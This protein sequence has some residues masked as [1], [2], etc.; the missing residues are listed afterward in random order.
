MQEQ[1]SRDQLVEL[2][3]RIMN[4]EGT[5]DE[6]DAWQDLLERNVLDPNVSDLIFY[7]DRE[8][9]AEEIV[10]RALNY[11]AIRL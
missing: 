9:T 5:E 2:V 10:E 1:L 3:R 8:M 4:A 7:P 11:K 6:I